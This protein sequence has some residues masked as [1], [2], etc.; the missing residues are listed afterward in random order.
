MSV[1]PFTNLLLLSLGQRHSRCSLAP[2]ANEQGLTLIECI[3]AI[4]VIGV[5]GA[6]IAPMM[7]VSVATRVQSQKAEQAV[8]LAQSEI[9]R[10]RVQFEQRQ[11][12]DIPPV[13][14]ATDNRAP[15]VAG[16]TSLNDTN[17]RLRVVDVNQ[18]GNQDFVVQSFLVEK[19]NVADT[20]EMGVRVYDYGAV[21]NNNGGSLPVDKARLG[22]TSTQGDRGEKPMATLYT[23]VAITELSSSL[24]NFIDFT[25]DSGTFVKPPSCS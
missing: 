18:D 16:P 13:I 25:D 22:M 19:T 11:L 17:T 8:E 12:I 3:M 21:E 2:G 5:T 15:N 24:C 20:Y 10:V 1:K 6:A 9:D 7:L 14:T 4:L 23:N